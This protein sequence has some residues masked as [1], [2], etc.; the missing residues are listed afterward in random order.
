MRILLSIIIAVLLVSLMSCGDTKGTTSQTATHSTPDK[1]ELIYKIPV[2]IQRG[3]KFESLE[4]IRLQ[5][6][7]TWDLRKS[8]ENEAYSMITYGYLTPEFVFNKG[9]MS[10]AGEYEGFWMD[11]KED[12]S[13]EYGYYDETLGGGIYHLR[14][15][16]LALLMLD[17]NEEMEPKVFQANSNGLA[18]SFSGRHDFG[19]NNGLNMKLMTLD[20]KPA[21][22]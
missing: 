15:D 16:D 6:K 10:K 12:F 18:M 9:E 7:A 17:N 4:E 3:G 1:R 21:R 20:K 8:Q 22:K 5:A 13:Y 2:N 19:V 14:L 11:F